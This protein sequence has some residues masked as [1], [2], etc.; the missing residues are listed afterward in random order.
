MVDLVLSI[1]SSVKDSQEYF[2][3]K[4]DMQTN[5]YFN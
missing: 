1:L 3:I 5:E 4:E 2:S